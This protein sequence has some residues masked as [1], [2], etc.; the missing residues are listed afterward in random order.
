M[1]A[2]DI[3][4]DGTGSVDSSFTE[5]SEEPGEPTESFDRP[6]DLDLS[7]G[8]CIAFFL[9]IELV[10]VLD[11]GVRNVD[12]DPFAELVTDARLRVGVAAGADGDGAG[13]LVRRNLFVLL[14]RLSPGVRPRL[15]P[16]EGDG[17]LV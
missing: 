4:R 5:V 9:F 2:A 16:S 15:F 14:R 12:G 8:G 3:E 6:E 11:D 13:D 17:E 1:S 7:D 10:V